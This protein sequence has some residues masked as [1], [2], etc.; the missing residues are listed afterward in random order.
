MLIPEASNLKLNMINFKHLICVII[1]IIPTWGCLKVEE[2]PEDNNV[3]PELKDG[4]TLGCFAYWPKNQNKKWVFKVSKL[5]GGNYSY[6]YDDT[7][8]YFKDTNIASSGY[9]YFSQFRFNKMPNDYQFIIGSYSPESLLSYYIYGVSYIAFDLN[10][11][12][13]AV[14]HIYS[15]NGNPFDNRFEVSYSSPFLNDFTT[16]LG[17]HKVIS[18]NIK[19]YKSKFGGGYNS[20]EKQMYLAKDIGLVRHTYSFKSVN[21]LNVTD[22]ALNL[23][24]EI[25][26]IIN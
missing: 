9:L 3:Y 18:S 5:I 21:Y 20:F 11:I 4:N 19:Y 13:D 16:I 25:K 8:A 2:V 6:M 24:F 1:V 12:D 17:K 15:W 26:K 14:S 22:S 7:L 10:K 23:L